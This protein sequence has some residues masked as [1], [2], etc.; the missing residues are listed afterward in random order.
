MYPGNADAHIVLRT[1]PRIKT[2]QSAAAHNE[3]Q[4]IQKA[5]ALK[6]KGTLAGTVDNR[7]QVLDSH[8]FH[9]FI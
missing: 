8:H 1:D 5:H 6:A 2:I 9:R 3:P 7:V 4:R